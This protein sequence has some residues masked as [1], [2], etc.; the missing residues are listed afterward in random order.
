MSSYYR[1]MPLRSVIQLSPYM[2]VSN[3]HPVIVLV[4]KVSVSFPYLECDIGIFMHAKDLW[5]IA[6]GQ[7]LDVLSIALYGVHLRGVVHSC[8]GVNEHRHVRSLNKITQN[9]F[10]SHI[11]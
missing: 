1:G 2:Y 11:L 10:P 3:Y 8:E 4:M 9:C 7:A 6:I 5:L